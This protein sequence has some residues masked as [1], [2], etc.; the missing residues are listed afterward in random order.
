MR[1]LLFLPSCL[2]CGVLFY[3]PSSSV[4]E[5]PRQQELAIPPE[6]TQ[7]QMIVV[8]DG[9]LEPKNLT[10][11][12]KERVAF[13][14]NNTRESLIT[15]DIQFGAN[16]THCASENLRI[17]EDGRVGSIKPVSP[18]DFATTCFHDPGRYPFTVRGVPASPEGL[19]GVITVE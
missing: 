7:A 13:F 11:S 12:S 3:L 4:S 10:I 5:N 8:S 16:T 9:G 18:K 2:L 19:S 1:R 14:L 6:G 15:L 17:N